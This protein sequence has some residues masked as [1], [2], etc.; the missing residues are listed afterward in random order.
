[1][2][3]CV[4]KWPVICTLD[5]GYN[6]SYNDRQAKTI[7]FLLITFGCNEHHVQRNIIKCKNYTEVTRDPID[8]WA[9][10]YRLQTKFGARL[11]VYTCVSFCSHG[12]SASREICL[13]G[14]VCIRGGLHWGLGGWADPLS[15]TMGCGQQAGGTH[16]TGMHSCLTIISNRL[17]MMHGELFAQ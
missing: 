17:Q 4:S 7:R 16:P 1:M 8:A 2:I 13:R 11:C 10:F 14:V 9:N 5:P 3:W 6:F 12:G 15:D